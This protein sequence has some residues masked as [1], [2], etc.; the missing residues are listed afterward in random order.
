VIVFASAGLFVARSVRS[1]R[2]ARE[3]NRTADLGFMYTIHA[4]LRRDLNRLRSVGRHVRAGEV[5]PVTVRDGWA[6][7][8][9]ELE[10]HH[11]AEDE[12]LWPMLRPHTDDAETR[13]TVDAMMQEHLEIPPALDAVEHAFASGGDLV[14]PIEALALLVEDHLDHEERTAFPLIAAHLSE[15]EWHDFL[16]AARASRPVPERPVF[17][18]WVLDDV[19]V[20]D[21]D[22][23]LREIPPPARL[24]YRHVLKP[25]Y[26]ARRLWALDGQPM[27]SARTSHVA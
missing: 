6:L 15:A 23:V 9:R 17:L 11:H 25:R 7:F 5:A 13:A 2:R 16:L 3:F 14:A 8:R 4:A 24:V 1:T 19:S 21:A 10:A 22:A 20:D 26:E 18:A 27:Q 12:K